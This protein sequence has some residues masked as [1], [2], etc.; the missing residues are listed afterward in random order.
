MISWENP[1]R[2]S[3]T[4]FQR[5][6]TLPH[7]VCWSIAGFL[8]GW[9]ETRRLRNLILGVPALAVAFLVIALTLQSRRGLDSETIRRYLVTSQKHLEQGHVDQAEFYL[10][11]LQSLGF[12]N[13]PMLSTRAAIATRRDRPD[14]ARNC[15]Q[16]MLRNTDPSEDAQAHYHLGVM[17]LRA[18]RNPFSEPASLAISH[19]IMTLEVIPSHRQSHEFLAQLYQSRGDWAA[20][21]Q[22]LEPVAPGN[23]ALYLDLARIYEKLGHQSNVAES[24]AQAAKYYAESASGWDEP[25]DNATPPNSQRVAGYLNWSAALI[26]QGQLEEAVAILT[27][28]VETQDSPELR[29]R[30]ATLYIRM[31]NALPQTKESWQKRW[32]LVTLS[33]NYDPDA[34]ESLA[35][36]AN[37]A[38]HA[39][40]ELQ[41]AAQKELQPYLDNGQAPPV[42]YYL[43][44]TAAAQNRQ[45]EAALPLLRKAVVLEP[46]VDVAWNNL[47]HVLA[48]MPN[49]DWKDA[50]RCV[51]EALRLNPVPPIYHETRGQIM[52]GQ[53]RW[54]EA[55]RDLEL[56]LAALPPDARIHQGLALAYRQL[57]DEDLADYHRTRQSALR[58]P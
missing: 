36:L 11:R 26:M 49:P 13:D 23:P 39:P 56:A 32:D 48:T 5:L 3:S 29:R 9:V 55:V 6:Q 35:I 31:T 47:A 27:R 1:W 40:F 14:L 8:S 58:V 25:S 16:E 38:G 57:G 43:V 51:N 46:R 4:L 18:I 7:F 41:Q 37:I 21:A 10:N 33:R 22:H 52:V 54:A 30:L 53:S 2:N 24:A 15:Y 42:A 44:G 34:R 12:Q 19:F 20:V 17:E 50:E 28:A 45:W